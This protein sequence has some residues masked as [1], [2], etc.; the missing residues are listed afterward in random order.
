MSFPASGGTAN[1]GTGGGNENRAAIAADIVR[2]TNDARSRNGLPALRTSTKLMEAARIHAE[3]MAAAQRSDH[4]INGAQYPTMQSRL[5][6]VGYVYMQA[7]ENVAWN[8]SSA[9]AAV[10]SWMSSSGHRANILD[11]GLTE[12]GAAMARSS[13]GEP[14]W[15][16]VFGRPR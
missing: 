9:Q 1:P 12:M 2:F 7:A 13:R 6:A 4:T 15:I 5:Q 16:Q 3:Q 11:Q 14:Y 10:N 8:Q